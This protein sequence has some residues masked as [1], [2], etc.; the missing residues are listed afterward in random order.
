MMLCCVKPEDNTTV[1]K[2][3]ILNNYQPTTK[4]PRNLEPYFLIGVM[5]S[6]ILNGASLNNSEDPTDAKSTRSTPSSVFGHHRRMTRAR[7]THNP[8]VQAMLTGNAMHTC[9]DMERMLVE[10]TES[11]S[12]DRICEAAAR[13][14]ALCIPL[15][16]STSD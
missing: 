12:D 6:H 2:Y 15:R 3:H 7:W 10:C 8:V 1:I 9:E 13:Q 5:L 4:K 14:F 11:H 16:S